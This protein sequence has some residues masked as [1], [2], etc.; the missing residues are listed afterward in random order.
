MCGLYGWI[1]NCSISEE[2]FLEIGENMNH[3][4]PDDKGILIRNNFALGFRRL[5][6][7]DL[8]INGHQP[9]SNHSR[10]SHIIFNGEIYNAPDLKEGMAQLNINYR[11]HSDTEVLLNLVENFKEDSLNKLNGMFSFCYL[12]EK[13]N[14][15][16]LARDRF[17][18]K[19]FFYSVHNKVLYFASEL[20]VLMSFGLPNKINISALNKYIR[21]GNIPSPETIYENVF[22]LSPGSFI[23]GNIDNPT[24]FKE[25]KWYKL[26][27]KENNQIT[28]DQY[29]EQVDFL[30][31]D[32]TRIRLNSDVPVGV[33]LSGGIDSSLI[34]HYTSLFPAKNQVKA[35]SVSFDDKEFNESDI[36]KEV[37]E[38]KGLDLVTLKMNSDKLNNSFKAF[39]N[40]GEP[41]S[42]SSLI[43]Q[44]HLSALAKEFATVFLSG[45][46]GDEAFA[47][48]VEYTKAYNSGKFWE[49]GSIF[50]SFLYSSISGLISDDNNLKQQLSKL[51][52]G[53]KYLGTAIRMN[54]M[55]PLLVKLINRKYLVPEEELTTQI[56]KAWDET[57]G[58][59]LVKRMQIYDYSF[60]LESDVLV[61][62]DRASMGNSIEVRSPFLDYRLVELALS[63][64]SNQNIFENK[65][66]Q[67]LRKLA[68][69]HLP[70][71]VYNAP[72]KG[73]GLPY[74]KWIT[75]AMKAEVLGLSKSNNHDFWNTSILNYIVGKADMVGYDMELIFWRIWMFEIWYKETIKLK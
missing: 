41:F 45:D 17:G 73:F 74:K 42:D 44:F 49:I 13:K 28:S 68:K 70:E 46:G 64:P 4:G 19:P 25:C 63:I 21:F 58:L 29:L 66:K 2:K 50:S 55:E 32:A 8:S 60:Y 30:L 65:G 40:I 67:I 14:E 18:V 57:K 35:I 54:Y 36:A 72:K 22:K 15:F 5:S 7:V 3:R 61:K 27:L 33:F 23:Q 59:P 37:A 34:A 6:I 26:P 31:K 69:I 1:G 20:P 24:S 9:M 53:P 52:V 38:F 11:G 62:V 10:D 47:G 75:E 71:S 39:K 43:N 12:D 51:S 16:L 48:Y 56:F